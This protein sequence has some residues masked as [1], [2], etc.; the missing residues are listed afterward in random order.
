MGLLQGRRHRGV[1]RWN[2]TG[3]IM[4]ASEPFL[5]SHSDDVMTLWNR[6]DGSAVQNVTVGAQVLSVIA[7]VRE[8]KG[9][10]QSSSS[11]SG[12]GGGRIKI[13]QPQI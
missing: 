7:A 4:A 2:I 13:L 1:R 3:S 10:N 11:V 6:R 12:V 8:I 5:L 9:R